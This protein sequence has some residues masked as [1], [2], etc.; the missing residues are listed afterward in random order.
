MVIGFFSDVRI[1]P[2]MRTGNDLAL[3]RGV[4]SR[5]KL[6]ISCRTFGG[7]VR[8]TPLRIISKFAP[9]RHFFLTCTGI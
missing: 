5:N 8:A 9:R 2:K 3:K 1:T 6:R 4:T 7:T